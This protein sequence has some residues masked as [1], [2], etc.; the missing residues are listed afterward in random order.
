MAHKPLKMTI[1][2]THR[3]LHHAWA[4]SYSPERNAEVI[5]SM[6]QKALG[7]RVFHFISR[8]VFRAIYFPQTTRRAWLKVIFQNRRTVFRLIK[9]GL[10]MMLS[11][12]EKSRSEGGSSL[13]ADDQKKADDQ[14][15]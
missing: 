7:P 4:A 2:E 1:D 12:K 9:E 6:N 14:V 11:S 3:E 15:N 13:A 5:Q 10:S 8:L